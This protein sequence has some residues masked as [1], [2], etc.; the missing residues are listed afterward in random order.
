MSRAVLCKALPELCPEEVEVVARKLEEL[1]I[2]GIDDAQ[3]LKEAGV[4]E[5][6]IT[7]VEAKKLIY[8]ISKSGNHH[9]GLYVSLCNLKTS[10]MTLT[11]F[12]ST[13]K[14]Q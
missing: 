1:E 5:G 2:K 9:S 3:Y 10:K 14:N 7:V 8:K 12:Q 13:N 11:C 4:T 6:L